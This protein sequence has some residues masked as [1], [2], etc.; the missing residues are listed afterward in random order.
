MQNYLETIISQYGN[1]PR[2]LQLINDLNQYIDPSVD[3]DNFYNTVWNIETAQGFGLD[4]WGRILGVSRNLQVPDNPDYFGFS[5][6]S[7][8]CFPFNQKSFYE[9]TP[10]L[11]KTYQMSDDYF[12]KLL[13][14]KA[15][16]NI[17]ATNALAINKIIQYIFAGRGVAYCSDI[18]NMMMR[19]TFEYQL[20]PFEIAITRQTKIFPVPCGVRGFVFNS[21]LPLFGFSQ[22]GIR[23]ATTFGFGV[24]LP[25]GADYAI[26]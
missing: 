19:Y 8:G 26:N 14:A 24:F 25:I 12:R 17:T 4:I 16:S 7:P 5:Q 2:L 18:G 11:T 3:I 20:Q 6:A 23:S 1:S 22:A 10:P 21:K 9:G 15:L 13:L